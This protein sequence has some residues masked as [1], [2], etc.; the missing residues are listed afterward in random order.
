MFEMSRNPGQSWGM[1][2]GGGQDRG[3][4]LVLEKV[5]TFRYGSAEGSGCFSG[6]GEVMFR[7]DL[8]MDYASLQGDISRGRVL[9]SGS[10]GG[11]REDRQCSGKNERKREG[12][13]G[14]RGREGVK[15]RHLDVS[16]P[17]C[18]TLRKQ[19]WLNRGRSHE[20]VRRQV[21][22]LPQRNVPTSILLSYQ[23]G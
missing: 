9:S 11:G 18:L 7:I 10:R 20:S 17:P 5:L 4:A 3:R 6:E 12:C 2:I 1:R 14:G 15:R 13:V 21:E 22:F 19:A 23:L 8:A 16:P